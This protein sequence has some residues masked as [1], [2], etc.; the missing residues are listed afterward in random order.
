MV[1]PLSTNTISNMEA[2]SPTAQNGKTDSEER[3][4]ARRVIGGPNLAKM[5]KAL[6]TTSESVCTMLTPL[7]ALLGAVWPNSCSIVMK[8]AYFRGIP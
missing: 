3:L 8:T 1:R 4:K 5:L 7:E 2:K 6:L